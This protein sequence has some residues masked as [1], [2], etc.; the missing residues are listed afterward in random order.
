[1]SHDLHIE[2]L[3]E[4]AP[5][6][7]FDAFTDPEAQKELYADAPDWI[8][9]SHC[10]LRVDGEWMISF[11]PP[12]R[13]PAVERNVFQQVDRPTRLAYRSTMTLPD[14]SSFDTQVEVTFE[15]AAG[16]TRMRL[17]QSRF[18]TSERRDEFR[19]GWGSILAE[20]ERVVRAR[21]S[22]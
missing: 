21:S 15:L 12:G 5:E 2:H 16:Q 20:L 22:S 18:P 4:A 11:G 13:E 10:D 17:V 6:V 19:G 9:E 8:V 7:V 14:G 3:F 1:V